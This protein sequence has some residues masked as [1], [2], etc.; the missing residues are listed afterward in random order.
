MPEQQMT[1]GMYASAY[2][3]GVLVQKGGIELSLNLFLPKHS[4]SSVKK[5]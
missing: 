4:S 5:Y 2:R 3:F 1:P